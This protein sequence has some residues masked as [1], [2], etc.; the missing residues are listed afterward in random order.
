[1]PYAA[2]Y[3]TAQE[4]P[5]TMIDDIGPGAVQARVANKF[6]RN[7][8]GARSP[9]VTGGGDDRRL[10]GRMAMMGME[11]EQMMPSRAMDPRWADPPTRQRRTGGNNVIEEYDG[12][13]ESGYSEGSM[14]SLEA[15]ITAAAVANRIF[16]QPSD[17]ISAL[18]SKSSPLHSVALSLINNKSVAGGDR[19]TYILIIC[20]L[21]IALVCCLYR[22]NRV[23]VPK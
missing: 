22:M 6:I 21:S 4:P 7:Q 2:S 12:D 15:K 1:M 23:Q 5:R 14:V 19:F 11:Q 3:A 20:A 17:Y 10:G 16:G 18:E 9:G 8:I 13:D